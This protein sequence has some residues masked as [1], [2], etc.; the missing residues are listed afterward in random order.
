MK[1]AKRINPPKSWSSTGFP[2]HHAVVEPD[3]RRVHVS[4]QVAWNKD[5]N[6]IGRGDA[7]AQ[8]RHAIKCIDEIL[9]AEGSNLDHIVSVH[10]FYVNDDDYEAICNM[11]ANMFTLAHG[12]ASTA[13][14]VA[15]LVHPDLMVEISAIAVIPG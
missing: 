14:R 3:G 4:G 1:T 12:P 15:R 7:A 13:V 8:T 2:F 10:V 11:R 9:Q 5:K 6:I